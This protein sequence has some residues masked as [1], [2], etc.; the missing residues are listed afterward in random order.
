MG[1]ICC[2]IRANPIGTRCNMPMHVTKT[3]IGIILMKIN[4]NN[5]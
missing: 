1:A 2:G 5:A 4:P 3:A